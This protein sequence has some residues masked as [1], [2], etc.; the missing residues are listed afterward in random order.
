MREILPWLF[1]PHYFFYA[2]SLDT[3]PPTFHCRIP[4]RLD[5]IK[6]KDLPL[7]QNI[8]RG[9]YDFTLLQE[10]VKNGHLC[11]IGRSGQEPVHI[12]WVFVRSV[13]LPYLHRTLILSPEEAYGDEAFTI[14][15]YRRK[16]VYSNCRY[17]LHN[18]LQL[19]GYRRLSWAH[20]PWETGLLKSAEKNS[21]K[22]LGE[23]GYRNIFG[24]RKF[25]WKGQV[26]DHGDGKISF[27]Q[28]E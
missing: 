22:K 18:A 6:E 1:H 15:R 25:F 12:R 5:R 17:L 19:L 28:E 7:L 2:R 20:A 23:A 14:P 3:P 24:N 13:Y 8:R 10:R 21:F 9:F 4:I 16:G 27:R 26:H 11:F